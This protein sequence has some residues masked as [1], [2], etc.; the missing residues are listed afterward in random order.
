MKTRPD[1]VS[2]DSPEPTLT[3]PD[4]DGPLDAPE[5]NK[6]LP[7]PPASESADCRTTRP[8]SEVSEL[9]L[10]KV[11]LPPPAPSTAVAVVDPA[12]M[13][14]SA[15]GP[16]AEAPALSWIPP[17]EPDSLLP[18]VSE[19]VPDAPFDDPEAICKSPLV[20]LSA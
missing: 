3:S 9:P 15:A 14:M 19:S 7:V 13:L 18:V 5:V 2:D 11:S 12:C 17:A 4:D 10:I 20:A 1:V 16:L 6:T 8:L